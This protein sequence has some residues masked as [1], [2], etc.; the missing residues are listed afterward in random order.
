LKTD[1]VC[2]QL[3]KSQIIFKIFSCIENAN[4]NIQ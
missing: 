2:K 3:K 4:I 1:N